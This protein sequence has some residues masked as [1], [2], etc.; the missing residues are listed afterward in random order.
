MKRKWIIFTLALVLL[1][2]LTS[3]AHM[4]WLLTDKDAPKV[5][6]PVQVEIGFGHKFPQVEQLKEERLDTVKVLGADGRELPLKKIS[7]TRYEFV[8]PAAGVYLISAQ[9]VPGFVTRT[10]QGMKMQNKKGIADANFCFHFDMA[11]KTFV[12]VGG[13]KRGFGQSARSTLEIVPLKDPR[14][15]KAGASLPVQVKF[16]GKA[17]AGAEVKFTH[18]HWPDPQKPFVIVGKTDAQGKIQVKLDKPGRWLLMAG[19]KTPYA[20]QEE[21]DEN[22]YAASLT[23]T[24]R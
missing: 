7:T 8:P 12:N 17:L 20:P 24:V 15:L 23:F 14:T 13:Q 4:F 9:L 2:P 6:E 11:A 22:F 3:Q 5:N 1:F 18:D 10:P 21:C 16:Q 19:H